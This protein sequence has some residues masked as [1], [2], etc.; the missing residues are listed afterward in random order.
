[1]IDLIIGG[2]GLGLLLSIML[3]PVF[4]IILDTSIKKGIKSAL[5]LDLGVL[6]SDLMYISIAYIFVNQ[7]A[8]LQ[9]GN[10]AHWLLIVGGAVFVVFGIL[11]LRKKKP[12]VKKN[13]IKPSE[14]KS[15]NYFTTVLKGFFLNAVN[16]G[17]LFYWL[18]IIGTLRGKEQLFGLNESSTVILYLFVI[19]VTF[20]AIDILKIVYANKLKNI[21]TPAWLIVINRVLGIILICFGFIFLLKGLLALNHIPL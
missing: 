16:P 18:T 1:L 4:F 10:N 13:A 3:G 11:T 8:A 19:L 2:V 15:N 7:V 20:F 17:V 5:F 21:L 14:L 6:I 12:K 9:E